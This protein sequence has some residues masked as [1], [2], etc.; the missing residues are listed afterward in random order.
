[1]STCRC[2]HDGTGD[3]PCHGNGYRCRKPAARRFYNAQM[4]ALPG[5]Q[6]KVQMSDTWACD[7]CWA[8]FQQQCANEGGKA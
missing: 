3:H 8:E 4:V 1:M 5:V 7:A 6:F 2:G